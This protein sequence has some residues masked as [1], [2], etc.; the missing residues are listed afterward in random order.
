[1]E[2]R[3]GQEAAAPVCYKPRR[4][5]L[6]QLEERTLLSVTAGGTTDQLINQALLNYPSQTATAVDPSTSTDV[7]LA[8][9]SVATD[10]NGDFVVVW[11]QDDGGSGSA[12]DDNVYARYYTQ[13]IHASICRSATTSFQLQYDGNEIQE[14][15]ISGGT[16]PYA[17][18][19][20]SSNDITGMFTLTFAGHSTAAIQFSE[21]YNTSAENA[22]NI[23][24]ALVALGNS[25]GIA[26][27]QDVTV[28]GVDADHY[29][30]YFGNN[31]AG[32]IQPQFN[33]T[34]TLAEPISDAPAQGSSDTIYVSDASQFLSSS[35]PFTP[36]V[37]QV[38]SE[39]MLVTGVGGSGDDLWFVT[40]GYNNTQT[41]THETYSTPSLQSNS[42]YYE[43][44]Y[45]TVS[46]P[47]F[48]P[49]TSLA[50]AIT[51]TTAT[52][53]T[54]ADGSQFPFSS[55]SFTPFVVQVDNEQML[56]YGATGTGNTTWYV[57]RGYDG[58]TA[59]THLANTS[60]TSILSGYLPAVTASVTR[61]PGTTITIPISNSPTL[62]AAQNWRNGAKHPVR[63]RADD[64]RG[65]HGPDLFPHCRR[66][67]AQR[68]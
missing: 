24:S 13:A 60:V 31:S 65:C 52:E 37:I 51:D 1:M 43:Y 38:D 66:G 53:I 20:S 16:A 2:L 45:A 8:G 4:L 3:G 7:M 56:V 6:D 49:A 30:I 62:T 48:T 9:K 42:Q 54:V 11:S 19:T 61:T 10:N 14:L 40:R 34:T 32:L 39:Q 22:N 55:G 57:E 44:Q 27:L 12:S 26:A 36:F 59:A 63:V 28:Q 67:I 17:S 23:Q 25:A 58:T 18:A 21:I 64:D 29:L 47:Q 33:A 15:T 41:A 5:V 35:V 68:L 46:T 50:T